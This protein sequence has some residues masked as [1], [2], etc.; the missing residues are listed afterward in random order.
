MMDHLIAVYYYYTDDLN[1]TALYTHCPFYLI[2]QKM[3]LD[4]T[5]LNLSCHQTTKLLAP[6]HT[7]KIIKSVR[8]VA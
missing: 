6:V 2:S 4:L 8:S 3:V 5:V 7:K 1:Y